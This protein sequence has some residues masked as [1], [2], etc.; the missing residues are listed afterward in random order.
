MSA[1]SL[2]IDD[3][4]DISPVLST[5]LSV[6]SSTA[7]EFAPL[8]TCSGMTAMERRDSQHEKYYVLSTSRLRATLLPPRRTSTC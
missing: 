2:D 4:V 3:T 1:V 8:L 7:F 6:P 5:D